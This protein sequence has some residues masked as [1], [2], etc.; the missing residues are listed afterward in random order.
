MKGIQLE[1][2]LEYKYIS[3][4]K[5]IKEKNALAFVVSQANKDENK[6][7]SNLYLYDLNKKS[8]KKMTS[9]DKVSNFYVLDGQIVFKA[10]RSKEEEE[11]SKKG[12]GES[13]FYKLNLDGGEAEKFFRIPMTVSNLKKLDDENFVFM[14]KENP[15]KPRLYD[16]EKLAEDEREKKLSEAAKFIEEEKSYE[17]LSH[18]PFWING[19]GFNDGDVNGLYVYNIKSGNIKKISADNI[20]ISSFE[21]RDKKVYVVYQEVSLLM[22][23]CDYLGVYDLESGDFTCL[24][25]N[26]SFSFF[27]INELDGEVLAVGGDQSVEG[28]NGSTRFFLVEN[29]DLND[30]TPAGFD[31]SI[32]S[33]INSDARLYGSKTFGVY[34][35]RFYFIS[36]QGVDTK[37]Y[38]ID[39][40]G[41]YRV[42]V[43]QTGATDGFDMGDNGEIYCVAF[44]ENRLQEVYK[45]KNKIEEKLTAFNDEI[46]E[47]YELSTPEYLLVN[48]N[49][50][51]LDS[52]IMKPIGFE[53]G[54]KYKTILEIH[55]GPKTAYGSIF[56][57]EMQ[58]LASLGYVVIFTNPRGSDGKGF[59]FS[60]IR[61]KYGSIDYDDIMY[62]TKEIIKRYDFIDEERVGV[63]GGSYGGYMTN[64][65][66]G[67]TDFF[68]AAV[69]QRSISNWISKFNTTD[70]GYFFV[71]DQ[72][73]V[74]PWEDIEKMWDNSP[75]KY[76]DKVKTPTLVIHSEEDYRCDVDQ[77]YQW[78]S[79]LKYFGVDTEMLMVRGENHGLSR[80]GRPK[81]RIERLKAIADWFER[82]I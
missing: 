19:G 50:V 64:W 25:K 23:I 34:D 17:R 70:I 6:Y 9:D 72:V 73:G 18:L 3:N 63:T 75:L 61:G 33:T 44:R 47:K 2:F 31:N 46:L 32:C 28:I 42:E 39:K 55:G 53:A 79:A 5:Y 67:H 68:K 40:L 66:V 24:Y 20:Q 30:I 56:F 26:D 62:F 57:S 58:Y 36:T 12:F 81:Q 37:L 38:S 78:Y 16:L 80:D 76:A 45:Y 60:D 13:N 48:N 59:D 15:K 1:T 7:D 41:D 52:F 54:K 11:F 65:I 14:A 35:D 43:D 27:Y 74:T 4:L 8:L 71:K 21:L 69:T 29:N 51:E 49:G 10:N 22:K 82:K 77:G